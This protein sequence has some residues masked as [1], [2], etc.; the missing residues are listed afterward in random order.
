MPDYESGRE[1]SKILR[2]LKMWTLQLDFGNTNGGIETAV[3]AS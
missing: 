2:D 3:S 1:E